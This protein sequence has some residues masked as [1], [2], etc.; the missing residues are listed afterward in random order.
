MVE[1]AALRF[2][3]DIALVVGAFSAAKGEQQLYEFALV[4]TGSGGGCENPDTTT[5]TPYHSSSTMPLVGIGCRRRMN[6]LAS[7]SKTSVVAA[8]RRA[9]GLRFR[10]VHA[11]HVCCIVDPPP[12]SVP[13]GIGVPELQIA[14][15]S[16]TVKELN[17]G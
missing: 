10:L 11:I 9:S 6:R 2:L 13:W 5:D 4:R 16:A 17:P 8:S 7:T 12:F 14:S 3:S 1:S 15:F